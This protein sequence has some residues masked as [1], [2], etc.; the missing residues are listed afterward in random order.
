MYLFYTSSFILLMANP[1]HHPQC[2]SIP[3]QSTFNQ[4]LYTV[5]IYVKQKK[6]YNST[7]IYA[8]FFTCLI[9][10]GAATAFTVPLFVSNFLLPPV[11]NGASSSWSL[12]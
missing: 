10:L 11:V 7:L 12:I 4:S 6:I 8:S 5:A 1:S 2:E 9:K 3:T